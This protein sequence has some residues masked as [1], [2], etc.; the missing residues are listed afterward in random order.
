MNREE[1]KQNLRAKIQEK[2]IYRSSKNK[3]DKVLGETL[4][5]MGID[6]EKLKKD[7]EELK[8]QGGLS[9]DITN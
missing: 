2:Q 9:F 3:K 7:L 4:S 1:L 6:K 5:S 8:K